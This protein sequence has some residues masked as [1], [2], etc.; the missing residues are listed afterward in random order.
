MTYNG[1][2]ALTTTYLLTCFDNVDPTPLNKTLDK[3]EHI[4][5]LNTFKHNLKKYFFKILITLLKFIFVFNYQKFSFS[6][7]DF[8]FEILRYFC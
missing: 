7:I 5:N 1:L 3:L 2:L 8:S 4:N 6:F